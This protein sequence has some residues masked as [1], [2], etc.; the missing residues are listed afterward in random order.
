MK[1]W[2]VTGGIVAVV[3]ALLA[4]LWMAFGKDPREVPFL[5]AGK[6]APAFTVRNIKTDTPVS[7]SDFK[8]KPVVLNFWASWCGPCKSEHPS[9]E[10]GYRRYGNDVQFLGM[11]FEDTL[12]NARDFLSRHGTSFPQLMDQHSMTSVSYGVSGVPETYFITADGIILEKYVGPISPDT[13]DEKIRKLLA[14][15]AGGVT[16]AVAPA[17][18]GGMP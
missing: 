17:A 5:L 6:P 13:L 1:R 7:I 12:E 2:I 10:W 8:G 9:L 15:K 3:V 16:G 18:Q 11:V 14:L 4:V